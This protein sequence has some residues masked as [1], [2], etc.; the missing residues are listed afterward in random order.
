MDG[1]SVE[2]IFSD[3][4]VKSLKEIKEEFIC[5]K[6]GSGWKTEYA[7]FVKG[8]IPFCNKQIPISENLYKLMLGL[9]NI[10]FLFPG[11]WYV[12]DISMITNI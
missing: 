3:L 6:D 9:E 8:M 7:Y 2:L 5:L 12:F 11:S 4:R 1:T 10:V